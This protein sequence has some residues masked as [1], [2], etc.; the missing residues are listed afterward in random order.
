[1]VCDWCKRREVKIEA[2]VFLNS[3]SYFCHEFALCYALFV[4]VQLVRR[5]G[6]RSSAIHLGNRLHFF[7]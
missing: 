2:V 3:A 5:A 6:G 1:M 4:F 7:D